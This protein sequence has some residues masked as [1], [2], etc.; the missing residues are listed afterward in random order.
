VSSYKLTFDFK[1]LFL[2]LRQ[3]FFIISYWSIFLAG[4]FT[5]LIWHFSPPGYVVSYTI[6]TKTKEFRFIDKILEKIQSHDLPGFRA[7]ILDGNLLE[8][9]FENYDLKAI[10]KHLE[11]L[12]T[13]VNQFTE[14]DKSEMDQVLLGYENLLVA[15]KK[16]LV[17][18]IGENGISYVNNLAQKDF[19]AKKSS[20][21]SEKL[22]SLDSSGE[23]L[24]LYQTLVDLKELRSGQIF[25]LIFDQAVYKEQKKYPTLANIFLGVSLA[26]FT[27]IFLGMLAASML[28]VFKPKALLDK[29]S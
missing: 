6:S 8:L 12:K 10:K 5:F 18:R 22:K 17:K 3:Y 2:F 20:G 13:R 19:F 24:I 7:L 25:D 14:M 29:L 23:A 11:V 1:L 15:L 9:R 16:D 28:G 4:I 27:L 21:Y 26:L